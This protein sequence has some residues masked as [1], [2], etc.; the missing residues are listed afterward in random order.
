MREGVMSFVRNFL[1]ETDQLVNPLKCVTIA[2]A[3]LVMFRAC[4]MPED[5]I[6]LIDNDIINKDNFSKQSIIWMEYLMNKDKNIKIQ[7]GKNGGEINLPGIGKVDG[8]DKAN[9]T[10]YQYHGC[11]YH[12]CEKCFKNRDTINKMNGKKMGYL[13]KNTLRQNAKI[14]NRRYRLIQMWECDFKND[15]E[16]KKFAKTFKYTTVLNPRDGFFGGR[17]NAVK[18]YHQVEEGERI[19]YQDF[20]SLYPYINKYGIYPVG[21]PVIITKF[22]SLDISKHQGM[23]KCRILPPKNLY[24]PVLPIKEGEKLIFSLCFRCGKNKIDKCTHSEYERSIEG[25]WSHLE[26]QKALQVGYKHEV[27]H[28]NEFSSDIYKTY[29]NKWLRVKQE[30]SDWP[31]DCQTEEQKLQY[32]CDYKEHEGIELIYENIEKNP[33]RRA[34]SKLLLNSLWGRLG[35][36]DGKSETKFFND[37]ASYFKFITDS[38]IEILDIQVSNNVPNRESIMVSYKPRT[39]CIQPPTVTN[40]YHACFTTSQARLKLY[41][42]LE[43]LG[44]RV[45]YHDTDCVIYSQKKDEF[46]FDNGKYLGELTNELEDDEDFISEFVSTGPKSYSFIT[47]K[48]KSCTKLKG[49][50]LNHEASNEVNRESMKEMVNNHEK[51]CYVPSMQ[52]IKNKKENIIKTIESEKILSFK[53]DTRMIDKETLQTYPWGFQK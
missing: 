34:V 2:S 50:T 29:V 36:R 11:F 3:A 25:T 35:M 43:T 26:I 21:H 47:F 42:L 24:H 17:T 6:G 52:F 22:D 1:N 30:S 41:E 45:L 44:D 5:T 28:F 46:A 20:T 27:H 48:G 4:C 31:D 15:N 18:L 23:I 40:L 9:N 33:G 32:I 49:F 13:Y 39:E 12:G 53:Y 16:M 7:H 38:S 10:V 37:P 8:Y 19:H 14:T 51:K